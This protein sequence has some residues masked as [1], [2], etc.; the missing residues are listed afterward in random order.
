MRLVDWTWECRWMV[1]SR[2]SFAD[3]PW[4]R[5][6]QGV[7]PDLRVTV[8]KFL[9]GYWPPNATA[10]ERALAK[11]AKIEAYFRLKKQWASISPEQVRAN[12]VPPIAT[13]VAFRPDILGGTYYPRN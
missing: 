6:I 2:F 11:E 10:Q 8:W 5:C 9:L 7:S 1:V 12:G 4:P 3:P 13:K